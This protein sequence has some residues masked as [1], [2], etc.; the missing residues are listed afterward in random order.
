MDKHITCIPTGVHRGTDR[1]SF[2]VFNCT[3]ILH[4]GAMKLWLAGQVTILS[5]ARVI[6]SEISVRIRS[7]QTLRDQFES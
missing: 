3:S 6:Y 7:E 1:V 4:G 2:S 5:P